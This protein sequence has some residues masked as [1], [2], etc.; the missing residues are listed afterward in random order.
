MIAIPFRNIIKNFTLVIFLMLFTS[1]VYAQSNSDQLKDIQDQINETTVKI[2]ELREIERDLTEQIEL[3]NSQI[4]LTELKIQE[5]QATI[6][7]LEQEIGVLGFR[8]GYITQGI[9]RLEILVKKR[10]V[11]TYQQSFVSNLELILASNDFSD[12]ILRLQYLKEVQE[13]DKKS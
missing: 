12:L 4:N 7:Q 5:S 13:N 10:I 9:D 2:N 11:A 3:I 1:S 8:I 6:D